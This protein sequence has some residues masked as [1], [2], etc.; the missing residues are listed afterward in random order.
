MWQCK[1]CK[2]RFIEEPTQHACVDDSLKPLFRGRK[3]LLEPIYRYFIQRL[4]LSVP[5]Q[6]NA[7]GLNINLMA[8]KIF[9]IIRVTED[10]L[11]VMLKL[12]DT[13]P[14]APNIHSA[15]RLRIPWATHYFSIHSVADISKNTM[16][17]VLESYK[18][19]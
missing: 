10:S 19:Q 8:P 11:E 18:L 9:A 7:D 12:S 13:T 2:E 15:S 5:L 4:N 6:M 17:A 1:S 14:L 16:Q 3:A